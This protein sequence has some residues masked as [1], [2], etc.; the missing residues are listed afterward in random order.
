MVGV[1]FELRGSHLLGKLFT[2]EPPPSQMFKV[3]IKGTAENKC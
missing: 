1:G 2:L 3:P